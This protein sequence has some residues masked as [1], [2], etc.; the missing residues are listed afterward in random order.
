M[1]FAIRFAMVRM[2]LRIVQ[3]VR[4]EKLRKTLGANARETVR[5]RFLM[6]RL[7]EE[8]LDL[9]GAFEARFQLRRMAES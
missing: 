8:W 5:Q 6:T 1:A 7:M 2:D 3:L 9:L 4:D